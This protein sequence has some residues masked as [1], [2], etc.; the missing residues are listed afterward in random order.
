MPSK[1]SERH[2]SLAIL[3]AVVAVQ[4]VALLPELSPTV[5]RQG[6]A[7]SHFTIIEGMVD[8]VQQGGNPL[9][10]WSPETSFGF[11]IVRTYQILAHGLVTFTYFVL[12]KSVALATLYAWASYLAILVL[13]VAVYGCLV[14]L[15]FP[16]LTAAAAVLL[17]PLIAGPGVGQLGM[18]LRSWLR[19]GV[20]PQCVATSLL[21][22]AIGLAWRAVRT[23]KWIV[24]A[25]AML[26]LT[27]LAH[28]VYGWMGALCV[29]LMALLPD[30]GIPRRPRIVRT[31][32][33]GVVAA[34]LSAFQLLPIL[35]DGY[36]INRSRVEQLEKYDSYGAAKVLTWLFTGRIMD[37]GRLPAISLLAFAGAALLLWRYR[38]TRKIAASERF[39]LAGALF[40][41]L[42][43]F[44]RPTW[45]IL[46]VMLGVTPDLQLH[47]VIAGVQIFLLML[48]A[49]GLAELWRR[50]H[51][52]IAVAA[53][54]LQLLHATLERT[55]YVTS[56][57]GYV[58]Q[59]LAGVANDGKD[60]DRAIA[61][62]KQRGGRAYAG[63]QG[64]GAQF[65]VGDTPMAAFL[66][67]AQL[68]AV[69]FP[70]NASALPTDIMVRFNESDAAHYRLFNV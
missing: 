53:K 29:C 31:L 40:W 14:M 3:V 44:G 8:A 66:N 24:L 52:A 62:L 61:W 11:P 5:I 68:P 54:A 56:W 6:D 25:G 59:D 33:I 27:M 60:L 4:A 48:A 1:P 34:L 41:I 10:F 22:V 38:T 18:E 21:L 9:D 2:L 32:Q 15:D 67:T 13:P 20:F 46:L 30:A 39:V 36:L 23:G 17:L 65:L 50:A 7:P 12:G 70:Y 49:I 64:W 42:V 37:N 26:G 58:A 69:A 47:R 35:Q 16:P 55:S 28:L 57:K 43:F 19:F 45:G 51:W 63:L